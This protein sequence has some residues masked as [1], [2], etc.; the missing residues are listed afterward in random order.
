MNANNGDCIPKNNIDHN[1]LRINW[2]PKIVMALFVLFL[3]FQTMYRE[4]PIKRYSNAHTGP[5][6]QLGGLKNGLFKVIYQLET[7]EMVKMDP[8]I[9]ASLQ[10]IID[11]INLK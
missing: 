7:E 11:V 9:P 6:T 4:I 10:I 2:I 1:K 8:K 5:N 3:L